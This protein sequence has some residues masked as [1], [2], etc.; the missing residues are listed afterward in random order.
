VNQ[1]DADG[2]TPLYRAACQGHLEVVQFLVRDGG[3]AVDQADKYGQTPLFIAAREGHLEVVQ[4]LVR[5]GGA[6]VDQADED[7]ET[8]LSIAALYGHLEVVQWLR[9]RSATVVPPHGND[10]LWQ[11]PAVRAAVERGVA[12]RV[13]LT[14]LGPEVT[15]ALSFPPGLAEIVCAYAS[16]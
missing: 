1:A 2:E 3:A 11:R 7:G 15:A 5:D 12:D 4:W 10:P 16:P 8:P 9:F 14:A 6:A 13:W